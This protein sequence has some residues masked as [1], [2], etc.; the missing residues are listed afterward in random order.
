MRA[1]GA[2]AG[3]DTYEVLNS[4]EPVPGRGPWE[5][6][7]MAAEP[8]E[9]YSYMIGALL[10]G[11]GMSAFGPVVATAAVRLQFAFFPVA[12]NPVRD[13]ATLRFDLP[14][15]GEVRVR[16]FDPAGRRVRV[17]VDRVL[18]AG[19]QTIV[20]DGRN[21]DGRPLASGIFYVRLDWTGKR[22][23]RTLTLLR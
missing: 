12:P 1:P 3:E 9:T 21:D 22:A 15:A 2:D 6:G 8:G 10:P 14:R 19:H 16:I 7:D 18:P 11:G 4:S 13:A 17:L 20:W 23:T 5:Y